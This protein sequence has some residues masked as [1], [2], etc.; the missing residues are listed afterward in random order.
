MRHILM[1]LAFVAA[2]CATFAS[3]PR[4]AWAAE[5]AKPGGDSL[6][7]DADDYLKKKAGPSAADRKSG[8]MSADAEHEALFKESTYPSAS[9]CAP[10]HPKQY[11]EWSVSQHAYSELSPLMMA[12]Q[13][14]VNRTNAGTLGDNCL[15][16]HTPLGSQLGEPLSVTNLDRHPAS[17]EGVTC[18]ACH[19]VN[20]NWGTANARISFAEGDIYSTIYGPSG[21]KELDRVLADP[22]E[23]R[24]SPDP[25]QSG[26]GIHAK[27]EKFLQLVTPRFCSTCHEV[28]LPNGLRTQEAIREFRASPAAEHGITCQDCHMSTEQGVNA[29][30]ETGPAAIVGGV[31]TKDRPLA[32]HFFAGPDT[33]LIHPGLFPYNPKAQQF[34]TMREW[35]LFDVKAGWGTDAFENTVTKDTKFPDAWRSVDDRYDGRKII[36][37]QQALLTWARGQRHTL[38]TH[39]FAVSEITVTRASKEDGID[40]QLTVSNPA[41]GH[42]SPTGFDHQRLDFLQVTVTDAM[43]KVVYKSGDRDPNGDVR[44]LLS[45]FVKTGKLPLDN[46][47]FNLQAR[48]ITRLFQGG[49]QE[50]TLPTNV[51]VNPSPFVR[52]DGR[53]NILYGHPAGARKERHGI[54]PNGSRVAA[55]SV[56]PEALTGTGPYKINAK[57]VVQAV[58][59]NFVTT[60]MPVGFDYNM[61]PREVANN[62]VNAA[63][64]VAEREKTVDIPIKA[65]SR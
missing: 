28:F 59:I 12:E 43:G 21:G 25:K 50:A 48:F 8:S 54:E 5:A 2:G 36:Q 14:F 33:S 52:P 7:D 47:L 16:C 63:D 46:D 13:N 62:L 42:N 41:D 11:R 39:G 32:S 31:P 53:P 22:E 1:V 35:L 56:P 18:V 17:R 58:P 44:D 4:H 29:G 57:F 3:S 10:C 15:R 49:E 38:L 37:E 61:A 64:I 65:A 24:V 26:R 19:R 30:F 40:F 23:Y 51:S 34:K 45:T 60:V 6:L 9:T 55:Y 20:K 27:A